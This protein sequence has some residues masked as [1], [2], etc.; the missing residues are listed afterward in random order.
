MARVVVH[1]DRRMVAD[2]LAGA[3]GASTWEREH[4]RRLRLDT[5]VV[6]AEQHVVGFV[7]RVEVDA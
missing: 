4:L 2:E 6:L 3:I 7:L 5:L 1:K